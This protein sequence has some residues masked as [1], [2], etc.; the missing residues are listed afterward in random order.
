MPLPT[1]RPQV[2]AAV[3]ADGEPQQSVRLAVEHEHVILRGTGRQR[4]VFAPETDLRLTQLFHAVGTWLH[5]GDDSSCIVHFGDRAF[6]LLAP[7][8]GKPADATQFL[9]ERTIQLQTAL[10][11][12]VVIEQAKGVLAE[13]LGLDIDEAFRVLRSA[14]RSNGRNLR[15]LAVEVVRSPETPPEVTR[16][17]DRRR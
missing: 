6:T 3:Q 12:R 14:A 9:L 5:N 2:A 10:E 11:T 15:E 16:L 8:D 17:A 4:A 7:Q 1:V 13:R